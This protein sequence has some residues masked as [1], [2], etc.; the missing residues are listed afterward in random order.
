MLRALKI[1]FFLLL[2]INLAENSN[3]SWA[4]D[5]RRDGNWWMAQKL[6]GKLFFIDG[7]FDGL[8]LGNNF[9]YWGF[10]EPDNKSGVDKKCFENVLKSFGEHYNKYFKNVTASQ[11]VDGLDTFYSDYKNRRILVADGVWLVLNG[12]A[13][14][15]RDQLEKMIENWRTN[16]AK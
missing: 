1:T 2:L 5:K 15:P 10:Y 11:L 14:T 7:F 12:I 8:N 13:G 16:A 9:S 6:P 4:D 3:H